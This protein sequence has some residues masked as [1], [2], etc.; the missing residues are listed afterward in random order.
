MRAPRAR[1]STQL[2]YTRF[3][4]VETPEF[5]EP[6]LRRLADGDEEAAG[7]FVDHFSRVLGSKLRHDGF[8]PDAVDDIR[9]ET[10]L[11][12]LRLIKQGQQIE[13]PGAYVMTVGKN[14]SFEYR[15]GQVRHQGIPEDMPELA[16]LN[17]R[18]E[19]SWV[20][21][22]TKK[23]VKALLDALPEKDRQLL[24][25]LYLDERDKDD[26]CREFKVDREYLRV[27][28]H[29]ALGK[30]REILLRKK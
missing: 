27:L 29:R 3:L 2:H 12:V 1:K 23:V 24:Q 25:G 16:D 14:V 15:R 19:D 20:T 10:L 9:Q 8:A 30:A 17:W 6:F 21:H 28:L 4:D 13:K 7:M 22:D 5:N 11:R 18:P 26:L